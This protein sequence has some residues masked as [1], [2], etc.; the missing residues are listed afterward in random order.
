M[1]GQELMNAVL[2]SLTISLMRYGAHGFFGKKDTIGKLISKVF[3]IF[4][5]DLIHVIGWW[6]KNQVCFSI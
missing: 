3:D 5:R 2:C 6:K 1:M 4:F